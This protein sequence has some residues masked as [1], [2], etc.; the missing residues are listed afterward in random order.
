MLIR[1]PGLA[2]DLSSS[3]RALR[4]RWAVPLAAAV[5]LALVYSGSA[6]CRLFDS[7]LVAFAGAPSVVFR[8]VLLAGP[9]LRAPRALPRWVRPSPATRRRPFAPL[10][11]GS[12]S[13]WCPAPRLFPALRVADRQSPSPARP[14]RRWA[15]RGRWS[16]G[17]PRCSPPFRSV[18]AGCLVAV[19]GRRRGATGSLVR[20]SLGSLCLRLSPPP[21][22]AAGASTSGSPRCSPDRLR[23][24]GIFDAGHAVL[25]TLWSRRAFAVPGVS[26]DGRPSVSFVLPLCLRAIL[27]QLPRFLRA[28]AFRRAPVPRHSTR[29]LLAVLPAAGACCARGPPVLPPLVSVHGDPRSRPQHFSIP[30]I[31]APARP[32]TSLTRDS[33]F[34]TAFSCLLVRLPGAFRAVHSRLF[35]AQVWAFLPRSF[36]AYLARS[37]VLRLRAVNARPTRRRSTRRSRAGHLH[38]SSAAAPLLHPLCPF[39]LAAR[40]FLRLPSRSPLCALCSVRLR[41]RPASPPRARSCV[42]HYPTRGKYQYSHGLLL[43]RRRNTTPA[44]CHALVFLHARD[45]PGMWP[46]PVGVPPH[47]ACHQS[48]SAARHFGSGL[49]PRPCWVVTATSWSFPPGPWSPGS[50]RPSPHLCHPCSFAAYPHIAP[51]SPADYRSGGCGALDTHRLGASGCP[52]RASPPPGHCNLVHCRLG[53]AWNAQAGTFL[54]AHARPYSAFSFGDALPATSA[55]RGA[56]HAL[57]GPHLR[58]GRPRLKSLPCRLLSVASGCGAAVGVF[59]AQPDTFRHGPRA[60]AS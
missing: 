32:S 23:M 28:Q 45:S 2:V 55:W 22:P 30:S 15:F 58:L 4:R 44:R 1:L 35:H 48:S 10:L 57:A 26:R 17:L 60:P 47:R 39:S 24:S 12:W 13:G 29:P 18:H 52:R 7:R 36:Q 37:P 19:A 46:A 8:C 14:P 49:P 34:H 40:G 25:L 31:L 42:T 27:H 16:L 50:R 43:P 21:V 5:R 53:L 51:A 38:A 20:H 33:N 54:P 41:P 59:G 3:G 6:G 56:T 11:R 9:A